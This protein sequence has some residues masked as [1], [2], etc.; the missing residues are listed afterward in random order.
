M[1]ISKEQLKDI[2]KEELESLVEEG[3]AS[4]G[5]L[6][7]GFL[8]K[9]LGRGD[10]PQDLGFVTPE[11]MKSQ[12]MKVRKELTRALDMAVAQNNEEIRYI[13]GQKIAPELKKMFDMVNPKG[14][15]RIPNPAD[16]PGQPSQSVTRKR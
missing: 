1:K 2:I 9:L 12:L 11:Q 5:E 13:L 16:F 14:S 10:T 7:E 6:D 3:G 8:D 4:E 15:T